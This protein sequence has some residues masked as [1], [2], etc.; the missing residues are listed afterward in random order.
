MLFCVFYHT[1][2]PI[3]SSIQS[4]IIHCVQPYGFL[5]IFLQQ[6]AAFIDKELKLTKPVRCMNLCS[7]GILISLQYYLQ[8][9][10]SLVYYYISAQH[11]PILLEGHI[12]SFQAVTISTLWFNTQCLPYDSQ[13]CQITGATAWLYRFYSYSY[14][15]SRCS[16]FH[17]VAFRHIC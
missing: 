6:L 15:W 12:Q 9:Y 3:D 13:A 17:R 11:R 10:T 4:A 1:N 5:D 8:L 14:T 16:V 2:S 7:Q